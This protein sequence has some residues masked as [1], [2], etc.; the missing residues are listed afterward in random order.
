MRLNSK[1]VAIIVL[2]V[3]FGGIAL[4]MSLGWWQTG[5]MGRGNG[6]HNGSTTNSPFEVAALFAPVSFPPVQR[7][8]E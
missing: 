4:T 2:V 1:V 7:H 5:G 8:I 6:N 3:I